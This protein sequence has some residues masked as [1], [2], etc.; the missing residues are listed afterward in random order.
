MAV[1]VTFVQGP[2]R[3]HRPISHLC[4]TLWLIVASIQLA[5]LPTI[6][7]AEDVD[8]P[9]PLDQDVQSADL[10]GNWEFIPIPLPDRHV[11]HILVS[12]DRSHLWIGTPSGVASYDGV[13]ARAPEFV[14]EDA[15]QPIYVN[16]M[17]ETN[18]G[19]VIVG[20]INDSLW[21][22]HD[23]RITA[24]YGACP[25][26]S[27]GCPRAEWAFARS[28]S[29]TVYAVSTGMGMARKDA[30]AALRKTVPEGVISVET[31]ASFLGF[32][33]DTLVAISQYGSL[34]I[35]D[36]TTGKATH[37]P[38]VPLESMEF[39][40]NVSFSPGIVIM[41]TDHKCVAVPINPRLKAT[42]LAEGNCTAAY[43][44]QDGTAW[45]STNTLYRHDEQGWARWAPGQGGA[46]SGTTVVEDGQ[47]NVWIGSYGGLWR[48][49]DLSREHRFSPDPAQIVAIVPAT[50]GGV[51]VGL[52]NGEIWGLNRRLLPVRLD[53]PIGAKSPSSGYFRGV[54]LAATQ[55]NSLWALTK[56]GLFRMDGTTI[57]KIADYP[58]P[59]TETNKVPSSLTVS[60][61]G[62]ACV[63]I[64]WDT[65]ILC[66]HDNE[67]YVEGN[68]LPH[69]GGSAVAAVGFSP[70]GDLIAVGTQSVAIL[71]KP[72]QEFGPFK[73]AP[74]GRNHLF[75][76]FSAIMTDMADAVASGGWGGTVFLRYSGNA[77]DVVE[78]RRESDQPYVVHQITHHPQLGLLA[79]SDE[80]L[81]RWEGPIKTGKWQSLRQIDPRLGGPVNGIVVSRDRTFWISS[82]A[83][84]TLISLPF[85]KPTIE[86]RRS[87]DL[88]IVAT[89]AVTYS[90][91]I[92]GLIGLP[93]LKA[94]TIAYSPPVPNAEQTIRG[95]SS[96][97]DLTDL[98]DLTSYQLSAAVTDGFLNTG[99]AT[100]SQFAVRL[101]FY[102]NPYKLGGSILLVIT[103]GL[104]AM[105]R[106]G[107]TGFLLRR[108][109]GLKWSTEKSDARFSV[110]IA[111]I[112]PE[113]V[114]YELEAPSALTII[115]LSADLPTDRL[116]DVPREVL[117]Y[118]IS[119]AEGKTRLRRE[120]FEKAME[121][122]AHVLG[123]I[124]IPDSLR[125]T[126][127]QFNNG[128]FNLDLGKSLLWLP[129]ELADDGGGD[130]IMMRY[131][132]GRTI[133]SD[134]LVEAK[135]PRANQ[136]NVTVFAPLIDQASSQLPRA[137]DEARAVA[138]AA[139]SWGAKVNMLPA[140]APKELV[141]K[142]L[143]NSHIFHYAGHA[144]FIDG[145]AGHSY[146]P[147]HNDRIIA[148]DIASVLNAGPH[149]L[150]LA[151]INGCG[152]SRED[153]WTR[154]AEV[155]G[156][157]SAFLSNAAYFIGT[158]WPIRDEFAADFA[159][160][161]YAKLFPPAYDLWWR[162][163]RR[164][165]LSGLPFAEALRLARHRVRET[166]PGSVQTWSSY[167]FYGDPTRRL[168]LN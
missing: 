106:R 145:D 152:S 41:G 85:S 66:L 28:E 82:G 89:N 110:E 29:G 105:T 9:G 113:T 122:A 123:D 20:T 32:A 40:R 162:L 94:T 80:G 78:A 91:S 16:S 11:T 64:S 37:G 27:E 102:R 25:R 44:Q 12:K 48:Y 4:A 107:P 57:T 155:Y 95:P 112:G 22:W 103:I 72:G 142:T 159:K 93:S 153:S 39:V 121:Q 42:I 148:D 76:A 100:V 96:R 5:L 108:L 7:R 87:P 125:F 33:G 51:T 34:S 3:V 86:M 52:E 73:P 126:T 157:A 114:R 119:I 62:R 161:Y 127:S 143:Q 55:D 156:F 151:F 147:T 115:R 65:R 35:I 138:A 137:D 74:F 46:I 23:G 79:A 140:D 116:L 146:L 47:A 49:L 38:V 30:I 167:V 71:S 60:S 90:L 58:A 164:E 61:A 14:S 68:V 109:G 134:R 13:T 19:A 1:C 43:L 104:A 128:A 67:W 2:P 56:A 139:R 117:P 124:A 84:V 50:D 101:P 36:T 45:L 70:S 133:S 132:I 163:L 17:V 6:A 10:T 8:L 88:E 81:Y 59:V 98:N 15:Q 120:T 111:E 54:L 165:S 31:S 99:T 77:I 129:L 131:A 135:P 92:P 150:L 149:N 118:L 158:Q 83:T 166:S 130:Q 26:T 97:L 53:F 24:I 18:D 136:L 69:F 168:I 160:E 75:G 63:G 144:Q 154:G 21:L 141:L